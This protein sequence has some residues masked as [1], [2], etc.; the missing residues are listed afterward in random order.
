MSIFK[1]NDYSKA[2]RVKAVYGGDEKK[3]SEEN[4]IKSIRNVFKLK[5][6]EATKGRI[7]WGITTLFKQKYNYYKPTRVGHLWNNNHI[8]HESSGD[9]NKNL[10]V[11]EYLDKIKA[12][13]GY[14]AINLQKSD[15]WK[16]QLTI[17][18]NFISSKDVD[19]EHVMNSKS[20][21]IEYMLYDNAND[22]VNEPFE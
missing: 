16:I 2:E 8:K 10:S 14:I 22:P 11:K 6:N 19:E 3:Q 7:I 17:A 15:T 12:Y 20:N 5:K 18:I 21:N 4:I 13:L 1:T 9:R